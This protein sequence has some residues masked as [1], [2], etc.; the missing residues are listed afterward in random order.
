MFGKLLENLGEMYDV[1]DSNIQKA[2][3]DMFM[4]KQMLSKYICVQRRV[5]LQRKTL[6]LNKSLMLGIS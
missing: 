3:Y 6:S 5:K 2:K 1:I 4:S